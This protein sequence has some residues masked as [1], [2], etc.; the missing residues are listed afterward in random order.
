[1]L[2]TASL[3]LFLLSSPLCAAIALGYFDVPLKLL[4]VSLDLTRGELAVI[5][6]YAFSAGMILLYALPFFKTRAAPDAAGINRGS[7]SSGVRSI[8]SPSR[9]H[10]AT[11]EWIVWLSV[12]TE[13]A[14]QLPHNLFPG[15]LAVRRGSF[16]E[17]PFYAYSLSDA[18][19]REYTNGSDG[20]DYGL[21]PDVWLIN[22]NDVGLG[23]IVMGALLL[24]GRRDKP[25]ALLMV[26]TLFATRRCGE[27][28]SSIC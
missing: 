24:Q 2:R 25:S 18:R 19:W 9:V 21:D 10:E 27:R 17:W 28:L 26:T 14:F 13:I 20:H 11:M 8:L 23:L 7:A 5:N 1:M 4:G 3:A 22:T 12:F 6:S 16:I 15:A